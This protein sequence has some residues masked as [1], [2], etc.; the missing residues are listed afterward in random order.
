MRFAY[1][2]MAHHRFDILK[3]LL[4]DLDDERND[5]FLHIDRKSKDFKA[6]SIKSAVCKA[7]LILVDRIPVFWGDFSQILCEL[8]LLKTA[9]RHGYHD[10]YHL[11]AGVE[12]PIKTQNHIYSFFEKYKG[13]E[14]VGYDNKASFNDRIR[15]YYFFQKYRR[16]KEKNWI[17][18]HLYDWGGKFLD[19]QM[20][21]GVNR[22]RYHEA[23]YK[24]GYANWSITHE[25]ACYIV[26]Q[27]RRIK[28]KYSYTLCADEVF[29]HTL[30]YNSSF[31]DK[32]YDKEDE[33]HSV[34]RLTTWEDKRNQLHMD[35]LPMILKSDRLFARKFDS[36]DA[37]EIINQI[38]KYRR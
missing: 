25:L 31:Y 6:D 16:C 29:L 28:R 32:V 13:Y 12:F 7:K 27:E 30:V 26:S 22:I 5:I 34:M 11:M 36:E 10:Y 4:E 23:E 14:F 2:I 38:I 33:Y 1:L 19:K 20:Q 21:R 17:E 8:Q 35:D 3:L 24:K 18:Q 37:V 9:V 15:Y